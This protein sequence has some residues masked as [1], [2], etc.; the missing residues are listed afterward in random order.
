MTEMDVRNVPGTA[1]ILRSG[2]SWLVAIFSLLAQS[3]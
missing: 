2:V 1:S 3:K